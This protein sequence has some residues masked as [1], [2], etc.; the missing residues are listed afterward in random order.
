[1]SAFARA[2][3]NSNSVLLVGIAP[4]DFY[5]DSPLDGMYFQEKIEKRLLQ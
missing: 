3:A 4:E 5:V 2:D 1:M